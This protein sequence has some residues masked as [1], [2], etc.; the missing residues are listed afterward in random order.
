MIPDEVM[1]AAVSLT[2][3]GLTHILTNKN[4]DT[5]FYVIDD[6]NR[7]GGVLYI[8]QDGVVIGKDIE[9]SAGQNLFTYPDIGNWKIFPIIFSLE[10]V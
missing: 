2:D 9:V 1:E 4:L 8:K 7:W 3:K 5:Y 10:N 6:N